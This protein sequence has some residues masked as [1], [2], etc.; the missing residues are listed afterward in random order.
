MNSKIL[1][2]L[3]AFLLAAWMAPPLG[4]Q[5]AKTL[6]VDNDPGGEF[7]DD[8]KTKQT[9][10]LEEKRMDA[11]A[12][13]NMVSPPADADLDAQE[14]GDDVRTFA[15]QTA[16]DD[17]PVVSYY[18]AVALAI[19]DGLALPPLPMELVVEKEPIA[20][21]AG[22]SFTEPSDCPRASCSGC[23]AGHRRASRCLTS[24]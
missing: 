10:E 12:L 9:A 17:D 20:I 8:A 3:L 2:L 19:L 23:S 4:A 22:V 5:G 11:A 6:A 24:S 21:P 7:E 14:S 18:G 1:S 15:E 16:G 13:L